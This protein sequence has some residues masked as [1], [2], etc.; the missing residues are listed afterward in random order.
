MRNA[1]IPCQSTIWS[2]YSNTLLA[3]APGQPIHTHT[4]YSWTW[5]FLWGQR[6]IT[7]AFYRHTIFFSVHTQ[8]LYLH[9][10][11]FSVHTSCSF[12]TSFS[13]LY[14][15][16]LSV[17]HFLLCTHHFLLYT[18]TYNN[19]YSNILR[20]FLPPIL[21]GS[22][23]RN[24]IHSKFYPNYIVVLPYPTHCYVFSI[25]LLLIYT[26]NTHLCDFCLCNLSFSNHYL[27]NP[28]CKYS[29]PVWYY[30]TELM[31]KIF[32]Y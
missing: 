17:H 21:R 4:F 32:F 31:L 20:H 5:T 23:S 2:P 8:L 28:V 14:T 27:I 1:P 13:S 29:V 3:L 24:N 9:T 26:T 6:T 15:I 25:Y 30:Y 11:F 12:Y 22:S 10:I 19:F 18:S 16:I 7:W